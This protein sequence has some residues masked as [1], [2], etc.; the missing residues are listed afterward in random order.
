MTPAPAASDVH[1]PAPQAPADDVRGV[2]VLVVGGG[3]AG[4]AAGYHLHRLARDAARGRGGPAPSFAILDAADG[5]GGAWSRY[6]DSLALFSP[7]ETSSLPGWRMPAWQGP[8]TPSADHVVAY[9]AEYERRY[10]LPV[11]RPVTVLEVADAPD[12]GFAVR[13]DRGDWHA[14]AV[15]SAT[16]SWTRPFL[17]H[18]PGA[19]DFAGRLLHTVDYRRAEDFAG[20]RVLVVGG[21]N[22][23]A[24]I[25]ADLAPVARSLTWATRRPP[26][27]MPDDVDGAALFRAATARVRSLTDPGA[28]DGPDGEREQAGVGALGDIVVLPPVRRARDAGLLAARPMPERLTADGAVWADGSHEPLDAVVWCTGFRPAL[29]HLRP[30]GLTRRGD[31]PATAEDPPTASA[32]RPG[33][34][35]LGYGDWCGPASATLVGVGASARATVAAAVAH[36]RAAAG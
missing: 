18:L 1:V 12:G 34:F 17:P 25:A 2:D 36:V 31:V 29:G 3:Q 19:E 4:L 7:A 15:I 16:G 27:W 23:G 6:W 8:G 9:L 33:L 14:R 32:D 26:R 30:L 11:H 24:Q 35:L 22:S 20:E 10:E 5:P 28:Q 13:T 21:G